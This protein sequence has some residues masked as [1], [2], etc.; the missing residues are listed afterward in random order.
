MNESRSN[1]SLITVISPV[2][3]VKY[4]VFCVTPKSPPVVGLVVIFFFLLFIFKVL[5]T[6]DIYFIS[7]TFKRPQWNFQDQ[8]SNKC[9]DS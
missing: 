2:E 4:I 3:D 1:V 9:H 6:E 7:L 8:V 5:R